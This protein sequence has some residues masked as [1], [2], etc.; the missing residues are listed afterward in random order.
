M[1]RNGVALLITVLMLAIFSILVLK[2]FSIS[3]QFINDNNEIRLLAQSNRLLLDSKKIVKEALKDLNSTEAFE[4]LFLKPFV[5]PNQNFVLTFTFSPLDNGLNINKLVTSSKRNEDFITIFE[6]ILS[7]YNVQDVQF[8]TDLI[9][10]TIDTD[11][12]ERSYGSE[13]ILKDKFFTNSKIYSREHF[14]KIVNYY[15]QMKDDKN[16][17]KIDW[18][19]YIRFDEDAIDINFASIELLKILL[20]NPYLDSSF[21]KTYYENY[22]DLKI[23][24][25]KQ[26]LLKKLNVT[27]TT[28]KFLVQVI[29]DD[30]IKKVNFE[31]TYDKKTDAIEGI[32]YGF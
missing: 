27:F 32:K 17:Y 22:D 6:N 15:V 24:E 20:S 1:S 9:L 31:F 8:F 11:E 16:I 23:D 26:A 5:I 18:R 4:F 13:I 12:T 29:F 19:K 7:S 25:D 30:F 14:D 28:S 21:K 10:D 2:S 3:N